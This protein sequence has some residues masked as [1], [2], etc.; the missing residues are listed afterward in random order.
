MSKPFNLLVTQFCETIG[1]NEFTKKGKPR[2]KR[3]FK[4]S[5]NFSNAVRLI[6]RTLWNDLYTVPPRDSCWSLHRNYYSS[7]EYMYKTNWRETTNY[8]CIRIV[9]DMLINLGY[10][11]IA[12]E[13]KFDFVDPSKNRLRS[14]R[15]SQELK[16]TLFGLNDNGE[17]QIPAIHIAPN[18]RK[19]S[20]VLKKDKKVISLG[21]DFPKLYQTEMQLINTVLARHW[22]DLLLRD[23]EWQALGER[24]A[25]EHLDLSRR[26]LTRIFSNGSFD[27]TGR[28]YRAWWQEIPNRVPEDNPEFVPYRKR[29]T[30][31]GRNTDELD[32][33]A[34]G[35]NIFYNLCNKD[36]GNEDPYSR[37]FKDGQHRDLVKKALNALI[38]ANSSLARYCPKDKELRELLSKAAPELG[39]RQIVTVGEIHASWRDLRKLILTAH[40]A[41]ADQFGKGLGGKIQF[42]DSSLIIK[43]MLHF[44]RKNISVLSVHDSLITN[45][46]VVESGELRQQM[47]QVFFERFG[48][49]IQIKADPAMTGK[50]VE[51]I[52][53][54][55]GYSSPEG[56]LDYMDKTGEF[57][58]WVARQR[59][60]LANLPT[61]QKEFPLSNNG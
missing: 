57:K 50:P 9:T 58:I 18:I 12:D 17:V 47:E 23:H 8:R 32:Y 42:E 43:V 31:D 2:R 55:G 7:P 19:P 41:V 11:I 46:D 54:Y 38:Q 4:E 15:P 21:K 45:W 49:Y 30:I 26:Q 20:I 34:L 3:T 28:L 51:S 14:H 29:I 16:K 48:K 27:N 39:W 1:S 61:I 36:I 24:L 6:L 37:V 35:P 5:R 22:P 59:A 53:D 10:I 44:G 25:T 56:Y 40:S 60:W 52:I 13:H 33:S